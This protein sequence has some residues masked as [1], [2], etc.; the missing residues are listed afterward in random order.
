MIAV[1]RGD[2]PD[3]V[4]VHG[5]LGDHRQWEPLSDALASAYRLTSISR[6]YHW[7]NPGPAKDAAYTYEG[8]RD[9]LVSFLTSFDQ[10]VHLAGHSYGAGVALL[11][12]MADPGRI[13]SL[14]LVEPSFG[15]LIDP[16][17]AD[18][19]AELAS[20][21]E[22]LATTGR[23]ARAGGDAAASRALI[24]WLQDSP[25]GFDSLPAA[26]REGLLANAA[27][28]GP[29][30]A[31]PAPTVTCDRL[32]ALAIPALVLYGVRTRLFFRLIAERVTSCLPAAS[33]AAIPD[34]GHMS[35]VENPAAVAARLLEFFARN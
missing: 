20:R 14:T 7:P 8:H 30:F 28:V 34:A 4:L 11:T 6:R 26:V 13:R 32:G 33:I 2:G 23:L 9:D 5:A 24:D 19:Q 18:L 29:T 3:V 35:I 15:G 17:A 10:P 25:R 22:L 27:T 1:T 12:A 16:T 21:Q 31:A